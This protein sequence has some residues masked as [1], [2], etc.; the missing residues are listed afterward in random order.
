MKGNEKQAASVRSS[1]EAL[2]E[3]QTTSSGAD[4]CQENESEDQVNG[5]LVEDEGG[6]S[7]AT[8]PNRWAHLCVGPNYRNEQFKFGEWDVL[9]IV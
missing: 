9:E 1:K 2:H 7:I 4:E 6:V 8:I 3:H 5:P